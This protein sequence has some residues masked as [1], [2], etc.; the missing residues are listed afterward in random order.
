MVLIA[1]DQLKRVLA[2]RQLDHRLR[3]LATEMLVL[4]VRRYRIIEFLTFNR[5][6]DDQ[7]VMAGFFFSVPEGATSM[8]LRPNWIR[9][10]GVDFFVGDFGSTGTAMIFRS[11]SADEPQPLQA[12][13]AGETA[14]AGRQRV[15]RP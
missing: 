11:R 3:L 8:S 14:G 7:L 1:E 5:F 6:V 10:G 4:V 2:G 13:H 9:T 15:D 12:R